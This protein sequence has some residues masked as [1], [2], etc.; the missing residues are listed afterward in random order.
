MTPLEKLQSEIDSAR[1]AVSVQSYAMSVGELATMYQAG[2]LVLNPRFQ[3]FYRWTLDQ[4]ARLIE[5]LLLDLPIPPIFVQQGIDGEWEVIDGLQRLSCVFDFMGVL[6]EGAPL[7]LVAT[8]YLPGLAGIKW[9]SDDDS[10]EMSSAQKRLVRTARLEV[11]ILKRESAPYAKYE[12][13]M[14]INTGGTPLSNQE[15]LN[16][17]LIMQ[18]NGDRLY[19]TVAT[20]VNDPVVVDMLRLTDR[21]MEERFDQE[22]FFR[23]LTLRDL[24]PDSL[25]KIY[26]LSQFM[27]DRT[28][29]FAADD[30]EIFAEAAAQYRACMAFIADSLG[31]NAFRKWDEATGRF[32]GGFY[33]SAFEVLA[34]GA[35]EAILAG[36][37]SQDQLQQL[38]RDMWTAEGVVFGSGIRANTRLPKTVAFGR[39]V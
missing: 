11:N 22:L 19:D 17:V 27:V 16:C 8:K 24:E 18:P 14:R 32:R 37:L 26:E 25:G 30:P 35:S 10:F 39:A 31:E 29:A 6:K 15:V 2:D 3:R 12:L 21:A 28:I 5:S 36:R 34:I 33:I 9:S 23:W 7:E 38:A 4:K 1:A 13:F 20:A